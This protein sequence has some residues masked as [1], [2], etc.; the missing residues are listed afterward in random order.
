MLDVYK[1]LNE[2]RNIFKIVSCTKKVLRQVFCENIKYHRLFIFELQQKNYIHFVANLVRVKIPVN[3]QFFF[4]VI[5][6]N[7]NNFLTIII[8]VIICLELSNYK[9]L[10]EVGL[11]G[12]YG[13]SIC[14]N[15]HNSLNI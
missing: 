6:K 11:L 8:I 14:T 3:P 1:L 5:L 12:D 10:D 7:N 15:S 2:R 9:L 4:Q 13:P